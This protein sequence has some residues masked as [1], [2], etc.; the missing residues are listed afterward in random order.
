MAGAINWTYF[1]PG[2]I[3]AFLLLLLGV[4]ALLARWRGGRYLRPVVQKLAKVPLFRRGI[5]KASTAALQ[6]ENPELASAIKKMERMGAVTDPRRAQK[7][8]S[9]LTAAERRAYLAAADQE[10]V[11]PEASNRQ[12]RRRMEKARRDSQRGR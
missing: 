9:T 10:G 3:L 6:R 4:M 8:L 5:A 7:A 2:Y 11:M 12:M 1:I